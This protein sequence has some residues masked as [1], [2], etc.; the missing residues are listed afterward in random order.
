[1]GMIKIGGGQLPELA[2]NECQTDLSLPTR[3]NNFFTE[4]VLKVGKQSVLCEL[5]AMKPGDNHKP[6]AFSKP[7]DPKQKGPNPDDQF[8]RKLRN[9]KFEETETFFQ[10]LYLEKAQRDLKARK[11]DQTPC[12]LEEFTLQYLLQDQGTI[13][14]A[15]ETLMAHL[16]NLRQ[17]KANPFAQLTLRLYG[18]FGQSRL[19]TDLQEYLL[20]ALR[21]LQGGKHASSSQEARIKSVPEVVQ[22]FKKLLARNQN[23]AHQA[24]ARCHT[25][26]SFE[27][28]DPEDFPVSEQDL[29]T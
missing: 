4:P 13:K 18:L 23:L 2:D 5:T 3:F 10:K 26:Q 27:G 24:L 19:N 25:Y 14:Y 6:D 7:K 12:S 21:E 20:L 17:N 28:I 11:D 8:Y 15:S 9:V 29:V 22:V 16:V 1:M